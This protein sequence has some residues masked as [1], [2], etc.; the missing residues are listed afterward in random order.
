MFCPRGKTSG[1]WLIS[2]RKDSKY[3]HNFIFADGRAPGDWLVEVF[4]PS[5][6]R[7]MEVSTTEPCIQLYCGNFLD[8]TDVSPSG[9][10]F[11]KQ[12]ALCLEAQKH[13]DAINH[14]EFA[15]TI[16]RPGETYRQTTIYRFGAR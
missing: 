1:L 16:L 13:P 5:T 3:D 4:D 15:N 2:A 6:G 8:G 9:T 14:P 7:T 11:R 12:Y 10:P